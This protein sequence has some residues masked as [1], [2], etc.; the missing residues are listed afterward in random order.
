M[1]LRTCNGFS[2]I[3][4]GF[5]ISNDPVSKKPLCFSASYA[6]LHAKTNFCTSAFLAPLRAK[7][8]YASLHLTPL[9]M[10]NLRGQ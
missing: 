9:C 2:N 5:F 6:A 4:F 10:Q 8:P 1:L 3:R 7:S